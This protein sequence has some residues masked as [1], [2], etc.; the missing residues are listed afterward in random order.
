M[1][2]RFYR[3][4][5]KLEKVANFETMSLEAANSGETY[6]FLSLTADAGFEGMEI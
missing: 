6:N 3:N 4:D 5:K 2:N 1:F